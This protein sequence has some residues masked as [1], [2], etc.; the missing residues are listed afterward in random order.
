MKFPTYY[1][2]IVL[3]LFFCLGGLWGVGVAEGHGIEAE[4]EREREALNV[5]SVHFILCYDNPAAVVI[6]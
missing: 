4:R 3:C 6:F 1:W 2:L 5:V